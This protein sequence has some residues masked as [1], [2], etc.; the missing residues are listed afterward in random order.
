MSAITIRAGPRALAAIARDGLRAAD[1]SV[2]PGAAGGPKALGLN[3]LDLA[4]KRPH[5]AEFVVA[6]VLK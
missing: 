4:E 1:I 2:V 5:A 6:P 3:G